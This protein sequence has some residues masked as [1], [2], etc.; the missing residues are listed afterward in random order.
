ME[1]VGKV[2]RF[3]MG[4]G[5]HCKHMTLITLFEQK[6]TKR[7]GYFTDYNQINFMIF[8]LLPNKIWNYKQKNKKQLIKIKGT[9]FVI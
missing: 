8:H 2:A 3:H 7:I 6:K 1:S 4:V 9:S 5:L